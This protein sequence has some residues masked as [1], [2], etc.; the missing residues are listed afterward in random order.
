MT[1]WN[2]VSFEIRLSE[3]IAPDER[4]VPPGSEKVTAVVQNSWSLSLTGTGLAA[5]SRGTA[6]NAPQAA[7]LANAAMARYRRRIVIILTESLP[8]RS[9]APNATKGG[10]GL[11]VV[12]RPPVRV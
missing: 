7:T 8:R 2:E 9:R 10:H 4:K 11:N 1:W 5:M 3:R 12:P 6:S